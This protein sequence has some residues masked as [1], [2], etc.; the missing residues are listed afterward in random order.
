V[1]RRKQKAEITQ[2]KSSKGLNNN[3]DTRNKSGKEKAES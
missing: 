1:E 2:S 3:K